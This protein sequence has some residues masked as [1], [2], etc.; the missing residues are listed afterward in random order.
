MLECQLKL[1]DQNII[2]NYHF[3]RN[4]LVYNYNVVVYSLIN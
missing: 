1:F 4:F 2:Y 3:P